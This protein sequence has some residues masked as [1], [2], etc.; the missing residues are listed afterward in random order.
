MVHMQKICLF[1]IIKS[2]DL[3]S[4]IVTTDIQMGIDSGFFSPFS[5]ILETQLA[6]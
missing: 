4:V 5:V 3:F 1:V 6:F 2:G